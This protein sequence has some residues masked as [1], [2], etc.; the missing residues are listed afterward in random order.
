MISFY[1]WKSMDQF[2]VSLQG[3]KG[4]RDSERRRSTASSSRL[5]F[6]IPAI[7]IFLVETRS[8]GFGRWTAYQ[9]FVQHGYPGGC[10]Q[11]LG[12]PK[13]MVKIMEN[14][15]KIDDL[16]GNTLI[17]WKHQVNVTGEHFFS[18]LT[19]LSE[20]KK[21]SCRRKDGQI[22]WARKL[23]RLAYYS[24]RSATGCT[25]LIPR[26]TRDREYGSCTKQTI[27][28]YSWRMLT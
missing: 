2:S 22:S 9:L 28:I 5:G 13:W 23:P 18:P 3:F 25:G 21:T 7:S 14:P 12:T 27:A 11:N 19:D 1:L 26:T 8:G 20:P 24:Q 15:I 16:G 4:I 10:F 17:F 6:P